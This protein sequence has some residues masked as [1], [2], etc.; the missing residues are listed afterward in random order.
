MTTPSPLIAGMDS[1]GTHT[2]CALATLTGEVIAVGHAGPGNL[3]THAA[4][5]ASAL[6]DALQDA[7]RQAGAEREN[8]R[9]LCVGSA[10]YFACAV[11]GG[12]DAVLEGLLRPDAPV[13]I[14]SDIEIA[15]TGAAVGEDAVVLIAGTGSVAYGGTRDGGR[16]RAG[17]WGYLLSDEGSAFWIGLQGVRAALRAFDGRGPE[18]ELMGR[19]MRA[20]G[21]HD[22]MELEGA[23]YGMESV[24][25]G[26][27]ALASVVINAAREGDGVASSILE[28][29]G[30]LLARAVLAVLTRLDRRNAR[31]PVATVGGVLQDPDSP[32]RRALVRSL[33]EAAPGAT[34]TWPALPPVGG[35][36]LRAMRRA[37]TEPG[38][39]EI[40]RLKA[41]LAQKATPQPGAA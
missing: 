28:E 30:R 33:S 10:G 37:G 19:L 1:G 31:I 8:V 22:P 6:R 39:D 17:G 27:A 18:T 29:G 3:C 41:G 25:T 13:E 14:V 35:A 20:L 38:P 24:N 4:T 5:A 15:F 2:T 12:P 34:V 23:V 9:A 7:M 16:A 40:A 32:V 21:L 36:L 26:V 11:P